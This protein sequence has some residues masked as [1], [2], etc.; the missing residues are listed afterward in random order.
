MNETATGSGVSTARLYG[1]AIAIVA[2][3]YSLLVGSVGVMGAT[4]MAGGGLGGW[5]MTV[6]GIVVLVHG[7]VLLTPAA[8]TLGGASGPLMIGYSVLMLLNQ[9]V[10]G[11]MGGYRM[12]T[13][14]SGGS[15]MD[16]QVAGGMGWDL[17]MVAIAVL[18][19]ISGVI[20]TTTDSEPM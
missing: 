18:M 12:G 2:G 20:M 19:L 4:G 8:A 9:A 6:L 17:G 10:G 16:G 15:M 7:F 3:L 14:M 11:S 5:V 13:G 1:A